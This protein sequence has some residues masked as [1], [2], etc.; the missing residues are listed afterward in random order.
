MGSLCYVRVIQTPSAAS[1]SSFVCPKPL[2]LFIPLTVPGTTNAAN[3]MTIPYLVIPL[4]L[5]KLL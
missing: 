2:F 5:S 1:I 4:S 3:K